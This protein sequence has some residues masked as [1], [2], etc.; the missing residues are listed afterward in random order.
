MFFKEIVVA[1]HLAN[2]SYNQGPEPIS[3]ALHAQLAMETVDVIMVMV[4]TIALLLALEC[5]TNDT[6]CI[7]EQQC[8]GT[9]QGHKYI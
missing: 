8:P 4:A 1:Q 9:G 7:G 2:Y 5:A 3:R 6:T